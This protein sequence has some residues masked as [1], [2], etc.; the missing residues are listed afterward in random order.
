[1]A[2]IHRLRKRKIQ[3]YVTDDEMK[4][5]KDKA[6]LCNMN[7]SEYFRNAI[8]K[9]DITINKI[10]VEEIIEATNAINSNAYEINKIG[11]NINQLVKTIHENNDTYSQNQITKAIIDFDNVINE[12][13]K[14][15]GV[16]MNKLYEFE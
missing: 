7:L 8:Y 1:M 3:F 4:I 13:E 6:E 14:L 10:P 11:N 12:Y 15:C 5:A 9:L 16:M 2:E